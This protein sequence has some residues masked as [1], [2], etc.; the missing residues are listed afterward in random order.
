MWNCK[1][2]Y[3]VVC[4]IQLSEA[5]VLSV[6]LK[7]DKIEYRAVIKFFVQEGNSFEVHKS[8]WGLF[9]FIFKN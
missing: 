6:P 4:F 2:F 1:S 3:Q 7:M 9:S 8:L 5:G